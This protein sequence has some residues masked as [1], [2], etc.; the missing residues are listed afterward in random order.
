MSDEELIEKAKASEDGEAFTTL[1]VGN[2]QG[3]FQIQSEAD[4][5]FCRKLAFW[6]GKNREQM[7]RIFRSSGMYRQKRDEKHLADG[8]TY[9]EE[10][11]DKAIESTE[12]IYSPGGDSPVFK[13][14]GRYWCSKGESTY[15]ITNFVF[16]PVEMIVSEDET[17]PTVALVTVR[18]ETYR[19]TFMST[20]FSNQ[21]KFK[22][23]LDKNTIALSYLGGDGDLELLK[24]YVSELEWDEKRSVKAMGIYEHNGRL[25]FVSNSIKSGGGAVPDIVQLDKYKSIES[26]IIGGD[27]LTKDKL[28][29]LSMPSVGVFLRVAVILEGVRL[30]HL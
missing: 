12:N 5:A 28:L 29:E 10:T 1:L 8:A 22:N 18:G 11:L 19:L 13:F 17:Q 9:S 3:A 23:L 4:M 27:P 15:P 6:F 14:Q 21:Q 24:G 25:V 20:D 2:W 7:E 26:G 16:Q 30:W